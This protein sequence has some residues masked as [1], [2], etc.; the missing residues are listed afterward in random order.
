[1]TDISRIAT[2][3]ALSLVLIMRIV[4]V[5]ESLSPL[6]IR[7]PLFWAM[8]VLSVKSSS[9]LVNLTLSSFTAVSKDPLVNP[10]RFFTIEGVRTGRSSMNEPH[11]RQ[12]TVSP[13]R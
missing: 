3:A 7:R 12:D 10:V 1:M 5:W 13:L 11:E 8:T 2:L 6:W 4:I 9:M